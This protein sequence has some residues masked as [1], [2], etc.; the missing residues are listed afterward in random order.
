MWE[1]PGPSL[2]VKSQCTSTPRQNFSAMH[3]T[4]AIQSHENRPRDFTSVAIQSHE[5]RNRTSLNQAMF[6]NLAGIGNPAWQ[7]FHLPGKIIFN[8]SQQVRDLAHRHNC[9]RV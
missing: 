3:T 8:A 9:C 2:A 6:A 4:V 7:Q 1:I 5:N